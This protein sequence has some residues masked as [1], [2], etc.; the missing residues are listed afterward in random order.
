MIFDCIIFYNEL[1]L[2][3]LRLCELNCVVDQF[4]IVEAP[5]T[6]AGQPKPLI[7]AENARQFSEWRG[8][9]IQV[10]ADDMPCGPDPWRREHHQRNAVMRGLWCAGP[11]DAVMLSDADEIPSA[12]V[13]RSWTPEMGPRR[14]EQLFS[15]YWLNCVGGGWAGSRILQ[16]R[17]H[18]AFPDAAA[19]RH[20]EFPVLPNGGWHFSFVGGPQ[21]VVAKLEAYSHQELNQ[22]RFKSPKYL[23]IVMGLGIDLFGRNGMSWNF[24]PVDDRFPKALKERPE[25][26]SHLYCDAAFHENWY[27]DDQ[28]LRA[29][30]AYERT[31]SLHGAVV[32][33]GCWEGRSTIALANA[34]HPEPLIAVNT[35]AGSAAE[36][37]DHVTVRLARQRDV[38]SQFEKNTRLL[39]GGNI[40]PARRDAHDFLA[41][42]SGP[43]KYVHLDASHDY[44]SVKRTIEACLPFVV[45]GGVICGDDFQSADLSRVDLEGGVERAV[46]EV[47]PGFE[48]TH[49]FWCRQRL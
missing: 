26:F 20:T 35:W 18:C 37:V 43:L 36:H 49:N 8:K 28:I 48:H 47:L 11:R 21:R 30:D 46:R 9:I 25:R 10:V 4:V 44:R 34:C 2:L 45:P 33:I 13:V 3:E 14:F 6:F 31:R 23:D 41:D 19:V 15:Y 42:W 7:L 5:V 24:C 1:D 27:P 22:G 17:E 12:D 32:E 39:T 16:F 40:V 38:F 29:V